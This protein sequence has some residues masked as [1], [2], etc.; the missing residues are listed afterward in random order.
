MK[1]AHHHKRE[2]AHINRT[3]INDNHSGGRDLHA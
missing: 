2:N 1:K 3:Q